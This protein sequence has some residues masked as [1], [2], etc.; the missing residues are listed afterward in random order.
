MQ[1]LEF[2]VLDASEKGIRYESA[3]LGAGSLL[4]TGVECLTSAVSVIRVDLVADMMV[5][6][7][8]Y[9]NY[10]NY[11]HARDNELLIRYEDMRLC[12]LIG[13]RSVRFYRSFVFATPV[14]LVLTPLVVVLSLVC[15]D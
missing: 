11:S 7:P 13:H 14:L 8:E 2:I 1:R 6:H 5:N 10:V 9:L 12:L 4:V 3:E 15:D